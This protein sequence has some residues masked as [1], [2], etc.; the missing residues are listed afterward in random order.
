MTSAG[1]IKIA[2]R[3]WL[4]PPHAGNPDAAERTHSLWVITWGMLAIVAAYSMPEFFIEPASIPRRAITLGGM[5]LI[6]AAVHEASRRS[7]TRAASWALVTAL[8][9]FITRRAWITGGMRAPVSAIYALF[10]MVAG[11]LLETGGTVYAATLCALAGG[12][13]IWGDAHGLVTGPGA[14]AAPHEQWTFLTMVLGITVLMQ[15]M[16]TRALRSNLE[17][18]R[19]EIARRQSTQ[20]RLDLALDAG[21]IAVREADPVVQRLT[22]APRLFEMFGIGGRISIAVSAGPRGTRVAVSDDG[23]D[24]PEELRG[25]L[26]EK[27]AGVHTRD[28]KA[29]HS[30]GL[31]LAFCKLAVEAHGGKI[32]VESAIPH[33]SIFA[34][35]LRAGAS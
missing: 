21:K 29:V 30:A 24:V 25:R 2:L 6:V 14:F 22:A 1:T 35:E 11:V 19:Q 13:L 26:F 8:I 32:S 18:A 23:R 31:G 16:V 4:G 10:V 3:G 17:V 12:A 7:H 15:R 34:F 28:R 27:F 33:G 5:T 9:V 20:L